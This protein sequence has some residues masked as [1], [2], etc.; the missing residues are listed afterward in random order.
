M[1]TAAPSPWLR[2][3]A[4]R[5]LHR[6]DDLVEQTRWVF[7]VI[8]LVSLAATTPAALVGGASWGPALL[9]LATLALTASWIVRY[10]SQ[11]APAA[12]DA[13]DVL[14]VAVFALACPVPP[15]AFGVVFPALWSRVMYG[16]TARVA[17]Y[18]AGLCAA[19]LAATLVWGLLPGRSGSTDVTHVAGA[20]PVLLLTA[21]GARHLALGLFAREQTRGRDAALLTLGTGLVGVTDLMAIRL[22]GWTATTEICRM[23]PGLRVA[24]VADDGNGH[25]RVAAQ[26]GD[27]DRT[28]DVLP[29]DLLP[30]GGLPNECR[31]VTD[32]GL[33][34]TAGGFTRQ[35]LCMPLPASPGRYM[36]LG[37][38]DTVPAEAVAAIQSM[39]NQVALATRGSQAH[40]DLQ[41]QARTDN[42]TGLA[43]R[44]AFTSA[45]DAAAGGGTGAAWVLF[46]D[47]D[48]FK[49]VNDALGHAAGDQLLQH[50]ATRMLGALRDEDLCARLGGD[51][52]G[53]L[54]HDAGREQAEQVGRRLVE[55]L[56]AP[57]RLDGRLTQV[58][59]SVGMAALEP[60]TS[61][62]GVVQ[63]ADI[64]MYAAKAAGK[65]RVQAFS[66]ALLEA[67]AP[68]TLELEL[69]GAASRG[70]FVV[71]Y[72]PIVAT[73]DGRCVAVEALVRWAHPTRGLLGPVDFL[74]LAE[75]TG[76]INRIGEQV[77]RRACAD[78]AG[79]TDGGRP[80]A[81]HV[82]ASPR[83]LAHPHFVTA[84]R[85]CL[86][87]YALAPKQLI[88]EITESS[89]LDSPA[90]Q[91]TLDVLSRLG[92]GLAVDDFGTGYSALTT[93]RTLPVDVVK[94]D[95]S[96]VAGA[97]TVVADQAVLEA[98]AQM[99][100]RLGLGT[101]A[102][103][104]EDVDQQRFVEQAGITA[105]QGYLHQRPVP[106]AELAAWLAQE[107][108]SRTLVAGHA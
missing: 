87:A 56:S 88:I 73:S 100:G 65:N 81:V 39:N 55:L 12:L 42:L 62:A 23:T 44:A 38:P 92:V 16:R 86:A 66:P 103:G 25:L 78:A 13:V 71:H 36:L 21:V 106:A 95:K 108:S 17:G 20:L 59:A 102:E 63:Q 98:I 48:D 79:W 53:V 1:S 105:V 8:A 58:G 37:A 84:V 18:A 68:S 83:Q 9:V 107:R 26:V 94:I 82:N 96:F 46:L 60:G 32:P 104:V 3:R 5:R 6:P 80:V 49:V 90:V 27:F 28:L 54:L 57:I 40:R 101:V 97:A 43:N 47:L 2:A 30:H 76:L 52:F 33:L 70:E 41:A 22:Q 50:M 72:Q 85:E 11:A 74:E 77:L 14:A 45:L 99:A 7:L 51:E 24:V 93:L 67:D 15:V 91:L 75:R 31:E 10:R 29:L 89:V 4:R 19:L 35:W 69:R 61:G 64:A 34:G